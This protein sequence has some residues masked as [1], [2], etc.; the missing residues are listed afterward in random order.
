MFVL[1]ISIRNGSINYIS[2]A[3]IGSIHFSMLKIQRKAYLANCQLLILIYATSTAFILSKISFFTSENSPN[4]IT[5]N[6]INTSIES[7]AQIY[8]LSNLPEN[9]EGLF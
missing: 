6:V 2:V 7:D 5:T 8:L 3:R 4:T 9:H 1:C